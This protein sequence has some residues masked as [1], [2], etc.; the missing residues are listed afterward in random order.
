M[1]PPPKYATGPLFGV[2]RGEVL[3]FQP[4][5][6]AHAEK[7]FTSQ[8]VASVVVKPC[9][10]HHTVVEMAHFIRC[11]STYCQMMTDNAVDSGVGLSSLK[12]LLSVG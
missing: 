8:I 6:I 1:P 3:G 7:F 11:Y 2:C 10:S 5:P 9:Q 4:N 12:I